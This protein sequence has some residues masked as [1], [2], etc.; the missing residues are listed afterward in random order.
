[1]PS[2]ETPSR[3]A[4]TFILIGCALATLIRRRNPVVALV[5]LAI[6]LLGHLVL[7]D[8]PSGLAAAACLIAV[9]TAQTHLIPPWR[10]GYVVSVY[11]GATAAVLLSAT[12]EGAGRQRLIV[13]AGV[14][15]ALTPCLLYTSRCV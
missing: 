13:V 5:S 9:Y 4:Y 12:P 10:W 14:L 3:S 15:A 7:L 2:F 6:L 8:A 11:L 1:M